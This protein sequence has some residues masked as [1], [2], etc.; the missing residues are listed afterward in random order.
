[1]PIVTVEIVADG[2]DTPARDLTQALAD[3]V[4]RALR[5]P[6]GQTWVRV[7]S[8]AHG[9]YAENEAMLD[10]SAM[11]VFVTV[12]ERQPA[13]AADLQPEVTALTQAI[14]GRRASRGLRAHRV[15]AGRRRSGV[16]RRQ[17]RAMSML[18]NFT[19]RN[20]PAAGIP[21]GSEPWTCDDECRYVS[22]QGTCR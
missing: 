2:D 16:V 3:A 1:M 18:S 15:R 10:R 17:A 11:P 14:A 21:T 12:L 20:C 5:S 6:P 4:G 22:R 7:R 8:L 9:A 13:V 19:L